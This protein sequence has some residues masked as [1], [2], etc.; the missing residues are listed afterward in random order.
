VFAKH[1]GSIIDARGLT[2]DSSGAQVVAARAAADEAG[3]ALPVGCSQC[4]DVVERRRDV[5]GNA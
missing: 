5:D 2:L 1:P 4:C 3:V